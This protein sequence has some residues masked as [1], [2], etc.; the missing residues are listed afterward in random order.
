[1]PKVSVLVPIY[2][3]NPEYLKEAIQS[4]L[5]QTFTDFEL[6][7]LDDCPEDTREEIVKSFHDKRIKYF[8]NEKNLGI[9]PSRNKL[10]DLSKGEYLAVMDHDDVALPERFEEE[11]KVLDTHPEIGVVS[12]WVERFPNKKRIFKN[13]ENNDKIEQYLMQWCVI[14]HTAAMIRK[15][16]FKNVRYEIEFSPCE[17]HRLWCQ[18]IGKTK[19][20]N[21]QKVLVKYRWHDNNTS[22]L[23]E[24]KMGTV[25]KALQ[26]DA[27]KAHPDIWEKVCK[28][29]PHTVRMKLFGF[30]PFGRFIQIGNQRKG[31]LKYLP[32]ITTRMKLEKK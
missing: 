29:A 32:F 17:D 10:I 24:Q 27:R 16:L 23:Q 5:D 26:L 7:I 19:F 14:A 20:Y 22:K 28:N 12:S 9:T 2:K 11:V 4:I 3:T 21:I 6:L 13:P 15:S 25:T 30:I 18:L 31:I 1:M 8:K